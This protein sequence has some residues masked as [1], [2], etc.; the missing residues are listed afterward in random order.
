MFSDNNVVVV[1]VVDVVIAACRRRRRRRHRPVP[2]STHGSSDRFIGRSFSDH[3]LSRSRSRSRQRDNDIVSPDS[4]SKFIEKVFLRFQFL[5]SLP[6]SPRLAASL[7]NCQKFIDMLKLLLACPIKILTAQFFAI[8]PVFPFSFAFLFFS[9]LF[10]RFLA[11]SVAF[12][13]KF[14]S[15]CFV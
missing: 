5:L 15:N 14:D 6:C 4:C 1:V 13:S 8:E 2:R 9:S 11:F 3:T 7:R 12:C 10:P